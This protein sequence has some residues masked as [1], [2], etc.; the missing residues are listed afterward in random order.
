[1]KTRAIFAAIIL[2][3]TA[4]TGLHA[5]GLGIQANFITGSIFAPG[6]A[7]V[8]S[9]TEKMHLAFNWYINPDDKN[10]FGLTFDI[11]PIMIPLTAFRAGSLSFTL[12]IGFFATAEFADNTK[13]NGGLRVPVGFS[14]M[15]PGNALEIY[16]HVA[17]SF[18]VSLLP[19]L[20]LYNPFFPIALG[21]RLWFR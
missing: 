14:F 16:T 15:M 5:F 1:M 6:A 4:V 18:G 10:I 17:P 21:I 19:S 13:F 12:G 7:V 11:R 8:I 2:S 9:P 3:M 20:N